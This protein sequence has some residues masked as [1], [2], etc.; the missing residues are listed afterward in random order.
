MKKLKSFRML[1][2][3]SSGSGKTY[4]CEKIL[5]QIKPDVVYYFLLLMMMTIK[6]LMLNG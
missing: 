4:L 6:N 2:S 3:G 1:I 5:E